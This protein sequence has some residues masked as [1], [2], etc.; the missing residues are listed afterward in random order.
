MHKAIENNPKI[1]NT[2]DRI[3]NVAR[4]GIWELNL[5]TKNYKLDK[6]TCEILDLENREIINLKETI[7]LFKDKKHRKKITELMSNL[8][9]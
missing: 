2:L 8:I 9:N 4:I 1:K 6:I 7:T 3:N 5:D